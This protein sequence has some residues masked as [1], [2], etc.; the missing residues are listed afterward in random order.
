MGEVGEGRDNNDPETSSGIR[1]VHPDQI[2]C[3]CLVNTCTPFDCTQVSG[4]MCP[5]FAPFRCCAALRHNCLGALRMWSTPSIVFFLV[6]AVCTAH[7][8]HRDVFSDQPPKVTWPVYM[9]PEGQEGWVANAI[10]GAIDTSIVPVAP[11]SPH[12]PSPSPPYVDPPPP[13]PPSPSPS[14]PSTPSPPPAPSPRPPPPSPSP[15]PFSIELFPPKN[16]LLSG[17][18]YDCRKRTLGADGRWHTLDY[19]SDR[20]FREDPFENDSSAYMYFG[21]WW[22]VLAELLRVASMFAY[23]LGVIRVESSIPSSHLPLDYQSGATPGLDA[24]RVRDCF[25]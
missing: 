4:R 16:V 14:P 21:A 10:V 15:P 17:V 24:I 23:A 7:S 6:W 5:K 9:P 8:A 18:A 2:S 12:S 13:S 11:P 25:P 22:L 3:C 20:A 1:Y 19:P